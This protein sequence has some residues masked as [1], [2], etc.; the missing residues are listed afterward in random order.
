MLS[1]VRQSW[2]VLDSVYGVNQ[3]YGDSLC[4]CISK[5][6]GVSLVNIVV[7][8]VHCKSHPVSLFLQ[9][10]SVRSYPGMCYSPMPTYQMPP[11]SS[12]FHYF[13]FNFCSAPKGKC[14]IFFALAFIALFELM[15]VGC[16]QELTLRPNYLLL[17]F[18]I[19]PLICAAATATPDLWPFLLGLA[20]ACH[21]IAYGL[22]SNAHKIIFTFFSIIM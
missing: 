9:V 15:L 21:A 12:Y 22:G 8:V 6:Y 10:V 7:Y 16:R 20:P 19:F 17:T 18:P 11:P 5:C 3:C 13:P 2:T 1:S 14:H 4:Y